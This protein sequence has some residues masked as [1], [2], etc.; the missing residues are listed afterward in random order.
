MPK[1]EQSL[2]P[3][4]HVDLMLDRSLATRAA[5]RDVQ[6]TMMLTISLVIIVIFLFLRT[7]WAT[8][9]PSLAVPLSLL[10]TFGGHVCRRL[11]PR[12]HLA[13]GVDD[14]GRLCRR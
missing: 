7:F 8:V 11:Q 14:L 2:P 4:V 10:A 5:V 13:D 1:L 6:F 9:I 12:Q 3:S